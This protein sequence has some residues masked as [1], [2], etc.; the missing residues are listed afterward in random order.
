MV[1][2]FLL[3]ATQKVFTHSWASLNMFVIFCS[4][5]MLRVALH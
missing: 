1:T 2:G 4:K 5:W 3:A